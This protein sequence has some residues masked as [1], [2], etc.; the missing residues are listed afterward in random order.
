MLIK[1]KRYDQAIQTYKKLL[2]SGHDDYLLHYGIAHCCMML[3]H[4]DTA[5]YH[6]KK[7]IELKPDY[8]PSKVGLKFLSVQHDFDFGEIRRVYKKNL[9]LLEKKNPALID[10]IKQTENNQKYRLCAFGN[11]Q[12]DICI[13][14]EDGSRTWL[15]GPDF[16]ETFQNVEHEEKQM[17]DAVA[18]LGFNFGYILRFAYRLT[19]N[20]ITQLKN[21]KIPLYLLE[22]DINIF[23]LSLVMPHCSELIAS[24]RVIF[25]AGEKAFE[26]FETHLRGSNNRIRPKMMLKNNYI[27]E[28]YKLQ[29]HQLVK[30]VEKTMNEQFSVLFGEMERYYKNLEKK[31]I[32][33]IMLTR[34]YRV[35]GIVSRFTTFLRFCIRDSLEGFARNG[36]ETMLLTATLDIDK[37]SLLSIV[38]ALVEFKPD[39]VFLID[40]NRSLY[41]V[42]P[43][44]VPV[45][46]WIQDYIGYVFEPE[47]VKKTADIDLFFYSHPLWR[48]KLIETGYPQNSIFELMIPANDSIYHPMTLTDDGLKK[49]GADI[50]YV[51]NCSSTAEE[52]LAQYLSK[53][54]AEFHYFLNTYFDKIVQSFKENSPLYTFDNYRILLDKIILETGATVDEQK[55]NIFAEHFW[56]VIGAR[57][58]R[59]QPLEWISEAGYNLSI[60]GNGWDSHPRLSRHAKG[61]IEN[62]EALCKLFNASKINLNVHQTGNYTSRVVDGFASDGFFLMRYHPMDYAEGG[63]HN[64]FDM[65]NDVILF[66]SRESLIEKI[67][68]YLDHPVERKHKTSIGREKIIKNFTYQ[69][70]MGYVIEVVNVRIN[71]L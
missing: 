25:F 37:I 51:A 15:N 39:L 63:L 55:R 8:T 32:Q 54:P 60:Y 61:W 22:P 12:F 68:Y 17:K 26:Q 27:T 7:S 10:E 47:E 35:L 48:D 34:K 41:G 58:F 29:V 30:H 62:G 64:Y 33:D 11:D 28:E 5:V 52:E 13:T 4:H 24:D 46:N 18:V 56:L 9:G 70:K 16:P 2:N 6:Y 45:I 65:E 23:R 59:Q 14:G 71:S 50:S 3:N 43:S 66:D 38:Q 49:Y 36:C 67:Q 19:E 31:H 42:I 57:L 21:Y 40:H 44:N 1:E 69:K 53:V 20:P